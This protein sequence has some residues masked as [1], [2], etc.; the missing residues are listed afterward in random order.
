MLVHGPHRLA[1]AVLPEMREHGGRIITVSSVLGHTASPGL[2]L[3][4]SRRKGV[5]SPS[6]HFG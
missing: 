2:G 1:Q 5:E 4:S 6:E 3:F